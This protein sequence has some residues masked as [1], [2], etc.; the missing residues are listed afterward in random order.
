MPNAQLARPNAAPRH[1]PPRVS[2]AGHH[3]AAEGAETGP[4]REVQQLVGHMVSRRSARRI[5]IQ[6][7]GNPFFDRLRDHLVNEAGS[8][9]PQ[10]QY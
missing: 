5:D 4:V 8:A 2:A 1:S 3:R 7:I 9:Q 6:P 10:T